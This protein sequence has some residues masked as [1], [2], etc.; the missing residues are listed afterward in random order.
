VAASDTAPPSTAALSTASSALASSGDELVYTRLAEG[1]SS[2][3]YLVTRTLSPRT[4]AQP[5]K[6]HP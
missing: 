6:D 4:V 2:I 5:A 1:S 3:A